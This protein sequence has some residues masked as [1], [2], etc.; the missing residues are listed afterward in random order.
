MFAEEAARFDPA[1]DDVDAGPV[2]ETTAGVIIR[3]WREMVW[4]NAEN[5]ALAKTP[6]QRRVAE[7]A[8]ELYAASQAQLI[9]TVFAAP[10][11][12]TRD[13]WCAQHGTGN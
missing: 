7:Q 10:D 9:R 11:S 6:A 13:A 12:A 4:R 1:F 5:L 2:D 8:I 3:G